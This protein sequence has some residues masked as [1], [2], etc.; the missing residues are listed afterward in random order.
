MDLK[1]KHLAVISAGALIAIFL[2]LAVWYMASHPAPVAI[3]PGVATTTP[4]EPAPT[5]KTI[6][7]LQ[8]YYEIR[9]KYPLSV[10][11]QDGG[12]YA[13]RTMEKW[14][15]DQIATF[16]SESKLDSLTPEDIKM[17]GLDQGQMYALTIAYKTHTGSAT[18]SYDYEIYANT[19]GAHPNT[20]YH[21]FTFDK[22][23]GTLLELTDLF[24]N[25]TD[26]SG[27]LGVRTRADLPKIIAK[28][29]NTSVS[30]V[31]TDSIDYGTDANTM[32]NFENFYIE[33]GNLVIVFAPYQVGP[34]ALGTVLDPI[35]LSSLK[36]SLNSKYL[37]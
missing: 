18:I 35:P 16:K 23:S 29:E 20:Y 25:E 4:T 21:T 10:P 12:A 13:Q 30:E 19:L 24:N 8:K 5:D 36:D 28:L 9:A 37:P 26:V 1:H 17:Q 14:V 7:D 6:I 11:T 27:M 32:S 31:D 2:G 33:N 3:A 34:Y 15:T 22:Q